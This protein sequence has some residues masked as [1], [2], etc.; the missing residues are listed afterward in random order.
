MLTRLSNFFL[1]RAIAIGFS[2]LAL[3]GAFCFGQRVGFAH[4]LGNF[5]INHFTRVRIEQDGLRVRYVLDMAEIPAFQES[6]AIDANHDGKV[7]GEESAAYL[8]RVSQQLVANVIFSNE[9][10]RIPLQLAT[11]TISMPAGAS[12]LSTLRIECDL[13]AVFSSDPT[14][15]THRLH[16]EDLN[17]NE[18][19]GWREVVIEAA[20]GVHVFNSSAY[21]SAITDELKSY[22]SDK[23][24]APRDERSADL[25]WTRGSVPEGAVAL[26]MRD[27]RP[28][29]G[30]LPAFEQSSDRFAA[31]INVPQLTPIVSLI[32]LLLA[33]GLGAMHAMSPGHGKTVVGAYLVGS[34]GTAK[35]AAFLGATVT[36]THTSSVFALGLLTLFASHYVLPETIFP[37]LSFASGGIV[38]VMGATIFVRRLRRAY[39]PAA[40]HAHSHEGDSEHTHDDLPL[41]NHNS[42]EPIA[43]SHGGSTHSHLPPGADGQRVTWRSLLVL[44]VSGGL[45]PCP[46]ALVVMLS[47]VSLGRIGYGLALILAF[48]FGLASTLTAVGLIF[49]YAGR[50]VVGHR[51]SEGSI[52]RLLPVVSAFVITCVGAVICYEALGQ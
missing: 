14:V 44:G 50:F 42:E 1:Q 26:R 18:R 7:S 2:L 19:V 51:A 23:L 38:L 20:P 35:H 8:E 36:L 10:E 15:A 22:P 5:T 52:A 34:K 41:H 4:P 16:F 28:A 39:V 31:L 43:H 13:H 40:S 47:A 17:Y 25:L 21:G 3:I 49:V 46:S 9:G 29:V 12:G 37:F 30:Q 6:Q 48:S 24:T 33:A 45:L 11:K 27:G 32:G